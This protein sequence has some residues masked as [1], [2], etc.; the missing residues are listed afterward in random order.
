MRRML[1][2]CENRRVGEQLRS[3]ER[4]VISAGGACDDGS[5]TINMY[6]GEKTDEQR[7]GNV[8]NF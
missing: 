8:R 5:C 7:C 3:D 4:C 2:N 6:L 1:R